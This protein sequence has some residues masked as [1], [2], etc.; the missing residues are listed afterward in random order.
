MASAGIKYVV[1]NAIKEDNPSVDISFMGGGEPT[2][3]WDVITHSVNESKSI[4]KSIGIKS[5]STL[6]TN[7]IISTEQAQW[8]SN[9][10]DF[11]KVSFDGVFQN[12]QR[13]LK[14]ASS[15][16]DIANRTMK[17]FKK[18]NAN[19][20]VRCT[21]TNESIS[22][23]H[24]SVELIVNE[25]HPTSIIVNP[26]YVCGSCATH[27][28][29]SLDWH[30][31]CEKFSRIQDIGMSEG[32][33]IVTPYDKVTYM[34]TPKTPFCGFV[35]GNCFMTPDGYMSTCSE[36]DSAQDYRSPIFFF[37]EYN[38]IIDKIEINKNKLQQLYELES[39]A[40]ESTCSKCISSSFC[41]GPCNVRN[42]TKKTADEFVQ[43]RKNKSILSEF[44]ESEFSLILKGEVSAESKVQ[45]N[46]TR[47]LSKEQ[48]IRAIEQS[49]S[50]SN[51][52]VNFKPIEIELEDQNNPM[53]FKAAKIIIA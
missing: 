32:V 9:E 43:L 29:G 27:G 22:K 10:V 18:N 13:P 35:K 11:I 15:S 46:M 17:I 1:Q 51:L 30:G 26:V 12:E 16:F 23:L 44:N 45:C 33:D 48:V 50:K 5:S 4:A 31:F 8:I 37:G 40:G 38:S 14:S 41:P 25:Y 49:N 42:T 28:V 36:I 47:W 24:E 39:T 6:T 34:D 52:A 7:G 3:N 53:I 21:V 20:L 19:F 2:L